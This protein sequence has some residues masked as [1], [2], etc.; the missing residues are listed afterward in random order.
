MKIK[1]SKER[2]DQIIKEET[3][4]LKSEYILKEETRK[5]I[6]LLE[7]EVSDLEEQMR[8][9][10]AED[11]LDEELQ[12]LFGLGKFDK[13]KKAYK[14]MKAQ[15][16]DALNKAYKSYDP[17]YV[18]ISKGLIN[19]L[20]QDAVALAQQHGIGQ[21]DV[22]LLYQDLMGIAQP[23][24]IATF[25]RQAKQGGFSMKDVAAGSRIGADD[26]GFNAE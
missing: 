24:D 11:E 25:Q 16:L 8:D 17:S 12:E 3:I 23:M 4:R 26:F 15:E 21:D 6:S 10:Y 5:K 1:I 19:T 14:Q 22:K 7:N 9:I 2:V 18:E 13:A 20:R